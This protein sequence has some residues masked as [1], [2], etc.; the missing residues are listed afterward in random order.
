MF[1]VSPFLATS[2][3]KLIAADIYDTIIHWRASLTAHSAEACLDEIASNSSPSHPDEQNELVANEASIVWRSLLQSALNHALQQHTAQPVVAAATSLPSSSLASPAL[4][5]W[6]TDPQTRPYWAACMQLA[7]RRFADAAAAEAAVMGT[8]QES[9]QG[10]LLKGWRWGADLIASLRRRDTAVADT[11]QAAS[12]APIVESTDSIAESNS[13]LSLPPCITARAV[14][15]AMEAAVIRLVRRHGVWLPGGELSQ[16]P[17]FAPSWA[18]RARVR[19]QCN[20]PGLAMLCTPVSGATHGN[21]N[22]AVTP[23]PPARA[24]QAALLFQHEPVPTHRNEKSFPTET[25]AYAALHAI[26]RVTIGIEI[27]PHDSMVRVPV[28]MVA[29]QSSEDSAESA[30]GE[31]AAAVMGIS[32]YGTGRTQSIGT[33]KATSM[34]GWLTQAGYS[35]TDAPSFL[36][37]MILQGFTGTHGRSLG[38]VA[39]RGAGCIAGFFAAEAAHL[40]HHGVASSP[41]VTM[42]TDLYAL[43]P[44]LAPACSWDLGVTV[45]TGDDAVPIGSRLMASDYAMGGLSNPE[46]LDED[47]ATLLMGLHWLIATGCRAAV[48][49]SMAA[50]RAQGEQARPSL[51]AC[52]LWSRQGQAV[53]VTSGHNG[54]WRLAEQD[55][56]QDVLQMLGLKE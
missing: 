38:R 50:M 4:P 31:H 53:Q 27:P 37:L 21:T 34:A 52:G 12:S 45:Q 2:C 47:M 51:L 15:H 39:K 17:S 46:L 20:M 48:T 35:P 30:R 23:L 1:Q 44:E 3:P 10:A 22:V 28:T 32:R 19:R 24:A 5:T 33:L 7:N 11:Q 18:S 14:C 36:L 29:N 55:M 42:L 13:A 40:A 49:G 6:V 8:V 56:L 25:V 16:Q 54:P 9:V 41:L 43:M 26:D